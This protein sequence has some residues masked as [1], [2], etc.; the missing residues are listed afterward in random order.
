MK[1]V[2]KIIE[3][4]TAVAMFILGLF[5]YKEAFHGKKKR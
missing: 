2:L 4:V 1:I 5:L 3:I